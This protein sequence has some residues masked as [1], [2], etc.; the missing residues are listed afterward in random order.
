MAYVPTRSL[1]RG[2]DYF[3]SGCVRAVE[4]RAD[5]WHA[6]V[7]GGNDYSVFVPA[8]LDPREAQCTCPMR[9]RSRNSTIASWQ[10][11][12]PTSCGS[13]S[14]CRMRIRSRTSNATSRMRYRVWS[15]PMIGGPTGASQPTSPMPPAF[16]AGMNL[17]RR[18][19]R[20]SG[21][22]TREGAPCSMSCALLASSCEMRT[23]AAVKRRVS[24]KHGRSIR[25]HLFG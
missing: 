21:P 23:L 10:T 15:G 8:S 4:H 19:L 17:R 13:R 24:S 22:N 6:T 18:L 20:R 9:G 25:D 14:Y 3:E 12:A 2:C 1:E 11:A 5:G 7:S 16:P